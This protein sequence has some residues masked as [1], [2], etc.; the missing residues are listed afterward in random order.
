MDVHTLNQTARAIV[1]PG[2]GILAADESSGTIQKR[3][4]GMGVS[5]PRAQCRFL[6]KRSS[7]LRLAGQLDRARRDLE[8]AR[9]LAA[10]AGDRELVSDLASSEGHLHRSS[11]RFEEAVES[12]HAAVAA[13]GPGR[14]ESL[15]ATREAE[16]WNAAAWLFARRWLEGEP[17][18]FGQLLEASRELAAR[19]DL[20]ERRPFFPRWLTL[21][22]LVAEGQLLAAQAAGTAPMGLARQLEI[23]FVEASED[24][25]RGGGGEPAIQATRAWA[26]ALCGRREEVAKL[27]SKAALD[28]GIQGL[29]TVVG[30]CRALLGEEPQPWNG[31]AALLRELMLRR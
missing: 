9:S 13:L 24:P 22:L 21:R 30:R 1:A 12:F 19:L 4:A 27:A 20:V 26:L 6:A 10:R 28:A 8:Q 25:D 17:D 7:L 31:Q 23:C 5:D 29:E 15:V 3:L 18:A 14:E 11:G 16:R 2:K